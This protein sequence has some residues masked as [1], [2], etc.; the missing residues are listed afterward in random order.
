MVNH[1]FWGPHPNEQDGGGVVNYYLLKKLNQIS[2]LDVY[3]GVP[4]VPEEL[5]A[6]ALPWI[7]YHFIET[8]GMDIPSIMYSNEIQA[9]NMF[10]IGRSEMESVIDPV[11]NIGGKLVLHQTIHWPD[12][13]IFK[14]GRLSEIDKIVAPTEYA[15]RMFQRVAKLPPENV[16][17]IPHG[18]D[19]QAFRR[20]PTIL[21]RHLNIDKSRQ[22]VILYSGR[23]HYWKGLAQII[24]IIRPLAKEFNCVFIIRGGAFQG[25]EESRKLAFIFNRLSTN[26][27]NVI[28]LPE[29][30]SPDFMEELFAMSDILLFNSAHEGFG[31]PLTEIQAVQGIPVATAIPNHVEILGRTG[32]VGVLLDPREKV[33]EVNDG[34]ELFVATSDQLYGACKWLLENPDETEVMGRRGLRNVQTRF[35]LN[36]VA[37]SWLKMY[38]ELL[39]GKDMEETAED[40]IMYK[41]E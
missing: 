31:C 29:W 4:K 6:S 24:P 21:E 12:D 8:A 38:A 36:K 33:G 34:R 20:R 23:L 25:V 41:D 9:L 15:K 1:L 35:D 17:V 11:H 32:E 14:S 39:F 7:N 16:P 28:F 27:P 40:R 13:D 19:L 22:K 5:D 37:M 30:R 26:N 3:H 18:V 2:P 10:H